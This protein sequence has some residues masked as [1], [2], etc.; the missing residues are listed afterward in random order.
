MFVSCLLDG[1]ESIPEA[2]VVVSLVYA[3]VLTADTF[4]SLVYTLSTDYKNPRWRKLR[5]LQ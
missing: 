2:K 4:L 5:F 1:A 3:E